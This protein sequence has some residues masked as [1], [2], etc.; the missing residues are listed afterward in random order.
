MD[1]DMKISNSMDSG[2]QITNSMDGDM[3]ISK[4]MD[5]DVPITNAETIQILSAAVQ[6]S[7]PW[8]E[9]FTRQQY[10]DAFREYQN[11]YALPY[12]NAIHN[13]DSPEH[14]AKI[15][16][17]ALEQGWK[18][19]SFWRRSTRIFAEKQMVVVYLAPMLADAGEKTFAHCLRDE[20]CRRRPKDHWK[21]APYETI[22]DSFRTTI[23]GIVVEPRHTET[24]DD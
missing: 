12:R 2:M 19:E 16:L 14:L 24:E 5:G 17:D 8:M 23:M 22:R 15:L 10:P 21:I 20:W 13:A 9:R 4:N 18:T 3:K 1:S 7:K 6:D 11:H